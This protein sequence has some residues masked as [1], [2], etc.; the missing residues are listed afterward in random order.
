MG[1]GRARLLEDPASALEQSGKFKIEGVWSAAYLRSCKAYYLYNTPVTDQ[2]DELFQQEHQRKRRCDEMIRMRSVQ[3]R[4][5]NL[6]PPMSDGR[7]ETVFG[8]DAARNAP[9][10]RILQMK[11]TVGFEVVM[12]NQSRSVPH[13]INLKRIMAVSRNS[14]PATT[15]P[16]S[17]SL[18]YPLTQFN[19]C[20]FQFFAGSRSFI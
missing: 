10:I 15:P 12:I 13:C 14:A 16:R 19:F 18:F 11:P 7:L 9:S 17:R 6:L 1:G 3:R 5:L 2:D 8:Q 4:A 20:F